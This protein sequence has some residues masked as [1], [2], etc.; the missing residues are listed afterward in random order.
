LFDHKEWKFT[1]IAN[2]ISHTLKERNILESTVDNK[3]N[4]GSGNEL[5]V[6]HSVVI[7]EKNSNEDE[8]IHEDWIE[9]SLS[10]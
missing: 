6:N 10:A 2:L 3:K 7:N 8:W 9:S 5:W 4:V 1:I